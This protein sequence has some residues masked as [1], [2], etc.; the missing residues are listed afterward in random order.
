[1]R[2]LLTY[3]DIGQEL[4]RQGAMFAKCAKFREGRQEFKNLGALVLLG[5]M[6]V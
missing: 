2:Y 3:K 4:Y 5:D 6:T 1:M